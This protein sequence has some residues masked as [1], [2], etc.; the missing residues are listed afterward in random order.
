MKTYGFFLLWVLLCLT[1]FA[2]ED[3]TFI[4][5]LPSVSLSMKRNVHDIT[6]QNVDYSTEGGMSQNITVAYRWLSLSYGMQVAG[7]DAKGNSIKTAGTNLNLSLFPKKFGVD[8]T[9]QSL[10]G[11]S[12][13]TDSLTYVKLG[14]KSFRPDL[15]SQNI[16]GQFFYIFNHKK[17]TY[18]AGYQQTKRQAKSAGSAILGVT[19]AYYSVNADSLVVPWLFREKKPENKL[20]QSASFL[21]YG[22]TFGYLH[23]FVFG[24]T[25]K[26]FF[27]FGLQSGLCAMTGEVNRTSSDKLA[28][29]SGQ[30]FFASSRIAFGYTGDVWFGNV[31]GI[32][33]RNYYGFDG[34]TMNNNFGYIAINFGRRLSEPVWL[35]RIF[36]KIGKKIP[37]LD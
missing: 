36:D 26:W 32:L 16:F 14:E 10:K 35:N 20:M 12:I 29:Y 9:Y 28:K 3:S 2:Q 24:K 17:F 27:N 4:H 34:E 22:L 25:K 33:S 5:K 6:Y 37:L 18:A 21:N 15:R 11:F 7:K 8:I 30:S 31:V 19:A 13:I 23:N 1:S